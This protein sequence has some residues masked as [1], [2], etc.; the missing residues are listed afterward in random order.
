M[1]WERQWDS[2][3]GALFCNW[4]LFVTQG[5]CLEK[6]EFSTERGPEGGLEQRSVSRGNPAARD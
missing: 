2:H 1:G 3:R 4:D 5:Y 6:G